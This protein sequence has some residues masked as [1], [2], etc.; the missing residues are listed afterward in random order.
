MA[1]YPP[2]EYKIKRCMGAAGAVGA[3]TRVQNFP[4]IDFQQ[5]L[6][7]LP[8]HVDSVP[9]DLF[10]Q[11]LRVRIFSPSYPLV[12]LSGAIAA[13]GSIQHRGN[14]RSGIGDPASWRT[15]GPMIPYPSTEGGRKCEPRSGE[16]FLGGGEGGGPPLDPRMYSVI[17][18]KGPSPPA[19]CNQAGKGLWGRGLFHLRAEN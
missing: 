19:R 10:S 4:P 3:Y 7:Y 9:C 13:A 8:L 17:T 11:L 6:C 5:T 12:D 2:G 16:H 18:V 15:S 1:D 14:T